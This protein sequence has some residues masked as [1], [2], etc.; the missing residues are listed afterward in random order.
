MSRW[1]S[2]I[3]PHGTSHVLKHAVLIRLAVLQV[4]NS[5]VL[6]ISGIEPVYQD[7]LFGNVN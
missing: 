2:F 7:F 4:R 5:E 6:L 1:V 3:S